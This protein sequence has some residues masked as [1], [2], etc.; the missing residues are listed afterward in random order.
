MPDL[1]L[2]SLVPLF[3]AFGLGAVD[4]IYFHLNRYRLFAHAES[5]AE[6]ALHTVRSWL[7]LP[8]LALLFL[9]DASGAFL[10]TAV[11]CVA[12]DQAVLILDLLAEARS[13]RRFGGLSAAEYQVHVLANGMH[14]IA[15]A[16]ALASRPLSAWSFNAHS[17]TMSYLPFEAQLLVGGLLLAATVATVQHVALLFAPQEQGPAMENAQLQA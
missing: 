4:G 14:G 2:I 6:H 3:G 7:V 12:L 10:W 11:A 16:L 8:V 9:A 17:L 15:L 5:R 1:L 13:R